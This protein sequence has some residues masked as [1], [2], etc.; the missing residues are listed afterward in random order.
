MITPHR[1]VNAL[2]FCAVLALVSLYALM[3]WLDDPTDHHAE[4]AQAADLQAAIHAE[5]AQARFDRAAAAMCGNAGWVLQADDSVRCVP[6]KGH[7]QRIVVA[8]AKQVQP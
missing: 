7:S 8:Y 5:A 4:M 2:I 1:F 6:R 3:A